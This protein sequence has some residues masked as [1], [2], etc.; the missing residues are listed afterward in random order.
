MSGFFEI[1]T[2]V[3]ILTALGAGSLI[4]VTLKYYWGER[5]TPP[6]YREERHKKRQEELR[7][8]ARQIEYSKRNPIVTRKASFWDNSKVYR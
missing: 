2:V 4:F 6:L 1:L 8:R 5:G 7:L 3:G